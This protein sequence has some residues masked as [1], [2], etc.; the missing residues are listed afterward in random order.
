[1]AQRQPHSRFAPLKFP[2][3]QKFDWKRR[4][5]RAVESQNVSN[6]TETETIASSATESTMATRL[7]MAQSSASLNELSVMDFHP[8]TSTLSPTTVTST[9]TSTMPATTVGRVMDG[10]KGCICFACSSAAAGDAEPNEN[11]SKD[12]HT[13]TEAVK[14]NIELLPCLNQC[15]TNILRIGEFFF[16]FPLINPAS[17]NNLLRMLLNC[18]IINNA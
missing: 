2:L 18:P 4:E 11:C 10:K 14:L 1:M 13:I 7:P 5:K 9:S 8:T 3:K 15:F 12:L 6:T 16:W 17:I